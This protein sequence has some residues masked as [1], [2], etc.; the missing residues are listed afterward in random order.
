MHRKSMCPKKLKKSL[1]IWN[2]GVF[3]VSV[4]KAWPDFGQSAA[5]WAR[6]GQAGAILID[7]NRSC[8]SM[9]NAR[10]MRCHAVETSEPCNHSSNWNV[11]IHTNKQKTMLLVV[12]RKTEENTGLDCSCIHQSLPDIAAL[13]T[14]E[15]S[16]AAG[17]RLG[18]SPCLVPGD[19]S[20]VI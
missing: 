9:T 14:S 11:Y 8:N 2:G 19:A 15:S 16:M 4:Y 3:A 13:L 20:D 18:W 7:A 6:C 10:T 12:G 17:S 5:H 1:I